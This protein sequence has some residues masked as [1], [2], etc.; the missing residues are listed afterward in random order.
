MITEHALERFAR[1]T[2]VDQDGVPARR[3]SDEPA[4]SGEPAALIVVWALVP[5][6]VVFGVSILSDYTIWSGE[7]YI[8]AL[9]ALAILL[10]GIAG[11][12]PTRRGCRP[13]TRW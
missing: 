11:I 9:P 2:R 4:V 10:G 5:P 12:A 8:G 7:Y 6:L 1:R 13:V 3:I